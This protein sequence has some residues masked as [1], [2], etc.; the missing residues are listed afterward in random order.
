MGKLFGKKAEG[1][2]DSKRSALFGS[3]SK[4]D[5]S[6][7]PQ[8]NPYANVPLQSDAYTQAKS[9]AGVPSYSQ[10][11]DSTGPP[12]NYAGASN[13]YSEDK[14]TGGYGPDRYGASGG[15]GADRYGA[16]ANSGATRY[17]SGG[18]GGLGPVP[19]RPDA[20]RDALFGNASERVQK[21]QQQRMGYG[22]PPP[23]EEGE[24][25]SH[26]EHDQ[27]GYQPY[28]DRQLT[29]EEEEEEDVQATKQQMRSIKQDDVS[30]TRNALRLA[31]QAE[32][33]GMNT[34]ARIGAQGERIHNT[35]KNLDLTAN[36]NRSAEERAR[37][38]KHLNRSIESK[39]AD[40]RDADVLE[41]HRIERVERETSRREGFQSD[42]RMQKTFRELMNE[43]P[44]S[45]PAKASLAERAKYQFEADSEDEEL[46][47]EI[48]SNLDAL[49]HA[50][51][52][53]NHLARAT[54]KE[55]D[56]Q[57]RHLERINAKSSFR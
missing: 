37:E 38:L 28:G 56:E 51:G 27:A 24:Q 21:Q 48:D 43:D 26:S 35:E 10:K 31:A 9:K 25:G 3:R 22:Q 29:A 5:K 19:N 15:Y 45:A 44:N 16:G 46:E 39:R 34:L 54:G 14:K 32:E 53:L 11:S 8:E 42:Q 33:Q 1:E 4:R 52:R 12:P 17:G 36:H 18:Y 49:G 30:A 6:P 47:N 50:A 55:V 57:N 20:N 7:N 41:K 23:Y 2:E 13:G 40:Q